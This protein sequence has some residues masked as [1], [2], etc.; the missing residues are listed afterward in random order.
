MSHS[1]EQKTKQKQTQNTTSIN[2]A[3]K[4]LKSCTHN[5]SVYFCNLV[6]Q[7]GESFTDF[8]ARVTMSV[9]QR[10]HLGPTRE[11]LIKQLTWEGLNAPT[12]NVVTGSAMMIFTNGYLS[13]W[14]WTPA[15][16]PL[17]PWQHPL[18]LLSDRQQ[19]VDHHHH[20]RRDWSAWGCGKPGHLRRDWCKP[21]DDVLNAARASAGLKIATFSLP[22]PLNP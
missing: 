1:K 10:I 13:L 4:A 12:H 20:S 8:L 19:S 18:T 17:L 11:M 5:P 22:T 2:L 3:F 7:S 6:Q 14:A 9:E 21:Q 16:V 15:Q